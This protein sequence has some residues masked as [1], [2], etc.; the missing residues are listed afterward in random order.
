MPDTAKMLR[1]ARIGLLLL[2]IPIFIACVVIA[3]TQPPLR[4][5]FIIIGAVQLVGLVFILRY[6]N[7][8]LER[9]QKDKED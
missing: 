4:T 6:I 8:A 2:N 9:A 5:A 3:V 1:Q 7:A